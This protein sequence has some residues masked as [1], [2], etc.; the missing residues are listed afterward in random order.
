MKTFHICFNFKRNFEPILRSSRSQT[1]LKIGALENCAI[2]KGKDL[3]W[4]LFNKVADL[5]ACNFIK[6]TPTQVFSCEFSK[7]LRTLFTEVFKNSF[8][9][10]PPVAS[11]SPANYIITNI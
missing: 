8:Y 2:I 5:K 1:F 11:P 6:K 9:R 7:F 10:T 3:S 4:S